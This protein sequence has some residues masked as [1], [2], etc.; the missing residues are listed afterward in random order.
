MHFIAELNDANKEMA[1]AHVED[2]NADA[3]ATR[4]QLTA[5]GFVRGNEWEKSQEAFKRVKELSE[6]EDRNAQAAASVDGGN[7]ISEEKRTQ[8]METPIMIDAASVTAKVA[9]AD[10]R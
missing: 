9:K 10:R 2:D 1:A 7:L 6:A 8:A 5:T 4:P 3:F